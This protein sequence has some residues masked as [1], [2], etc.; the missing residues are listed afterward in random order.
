MNAG[1]RWTIAAL[2]GNFQHISHLCEGHRA[3]SKCIF[4][5]FINKSIV[6]AFEFIFINFPSST[7]YRFTKKHFEFN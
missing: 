5:F 7:F 4:L 6:L 2:E 3:H 1:W